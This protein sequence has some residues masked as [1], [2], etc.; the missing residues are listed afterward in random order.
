[1]TETRPAPSFRPTVASRVRRWSWRAAAQTIQATV[2]GAFVGYD[3]EKMHARI[4]LYILYSILYLSLL[5]LFFCWSFCMLL[6]LDLNPACV[7]LS[8]GQGR[9]F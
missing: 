9:S 4:V 2:C 3:G 8:G 7:A 1:M 6:I 5:D